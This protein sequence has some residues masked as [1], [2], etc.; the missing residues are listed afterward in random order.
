MEVR[1]VPSIS[2]AT[3]SSDIDIYMRNE[4]GGNE[5]TEEEVEQWNLEMD[6]AE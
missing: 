2:S 6:I 1:V 4:I 3:S 5:P